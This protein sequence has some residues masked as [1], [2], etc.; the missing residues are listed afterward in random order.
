MNAAD[1]YMQFKSN[2]EIQFRSFDGAKALTGYQ[3]EVK[4]ASANQ[5]KVGLGSL[6]LILK[7]HDLDQV[8]DVRTIL[9]RGGAARQ[10][11]ESNVKELIKKTSPGF[12]EKKYIDLINNKVKKGEIEG[13]YYAMGSSYYLHKIITTIT[14]T[15]KKNQVCEDIILYASSQ[16]VVSA[17]YYKL[18]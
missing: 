7:L 14:N 16:S 9:S 17:P 10:T 15:E 6:N 2:V 18:E 1:L 4:G 11:L 13:F 12:T 8:P 3:G 5:G